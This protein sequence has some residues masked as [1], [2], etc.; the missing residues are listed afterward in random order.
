MTP[1]QSGDPRLRPVLVVDDHELVR[2]ALVGSL[3]E[4]GI[5][6]YAC[7]QVSISG[8]LAEAATLPPGVVLLDLDLGVG[9]GGEHIDGIDA[10]KHLRATGWTVVVLTGSP[11][12]RAGR[13]AAAVAAGAVGQVPKVSSFEKLI[14]MVR[15]AV[16]GAPLMSQEERRAWLDRDRAERSVVAR[17][18][19]LL[20]RLTAR[21]RFV[22]EQLA[23]GRRA[24]EIATESVV[25]VTTVR[26]QIRAILIKLEVGSQ[27]GAVA[28]LRDG[29]E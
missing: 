14:G 24:A 29:Q 7:T 18:A 11:G 17:K 27:L 3:R 28:L 15:Q 9:P 19:E 26:S 8:I 21:E 10:I 5:S 25:S 16:V 1:G 20:S 22:L 4:E 6:A 13:I 12:P 23:T 2:A